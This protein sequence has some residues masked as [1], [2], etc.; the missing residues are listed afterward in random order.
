MKAKIVRTGLRP[1]RENAILWA[2]DRLREIDRDLYVV[3]CRIMDLE[4]EVCGRFREFDRD[5]NR[6]I[7]EHLLIDRI[8]HMLSRYD[9]DMFD[10]HR[11]E[12]GY[13]EYYD[14]GDY[15]YGTKR[16]ISRE[17]SRGISQ[18]ISDAFA[19]LGERVSEFVKEQ[20]QHQPAPVPT[21]PPTPT[22]TPTPVPAAPP[23]AP[24]APAATQAD[25]AALQAQLAALQQQLAA[26]TPAAP[27]ADTSGAGG[28][29]K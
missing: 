17:I 21:A 27:P 18:G 14:D 6:D 12:G 10:R 9:Q 25:V 29:T 13:Y 28:G 15:D 7:P 16:S 26:L 8:Y 4:F 11:R 2:S 5:L 19:G 20:E 24:P 1:V 3:N 23:A 22:P